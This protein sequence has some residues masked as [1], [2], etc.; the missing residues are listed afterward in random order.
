MIFPPD[1]GFDIGRRSGEPPRMSNLSSQARRLAAGGQTGTYALNDEAV[2]RVRA[3]EPVLMLT[4]GDPQTPPHPA[5]VAATTE[6]VT[7]GRTHYS[8]VLGEPELRAAVAVAEGAA[9]DNVVI[10]PGAQAAGFAAISAVAESGDE[11]ILSDPHYATYPGIVAAT[12]ASAR[13]VPVRDDLSFDVAAIAAA[14][15]P[16]TRAIFLTSPSNPTGAALRAEDHAVLADLCVRHNLWLVIDEVYRHFRYDGAHV[17]AWA[18]GPA[19]RTIVL[20]SLS[21]SHAMTGYRLGWLIVPEPLIP[22]LDG[23]SA[24]ALFGVSQFVQDA[25]VAALALPEAALAAYRQGFA[26]RAA[27]V[28]ERANAMA[29]V[30][31]RMPAGGM[32][33]MLDIRGLMADDQA[34]ATR[35]LREHQVAVNPGSLFG[36][37]G[38]GHLRLSLTPDA[39]VLEEAMAR[40]GRL[41]AAIRRG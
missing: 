21:K 16:R 28:V 6:A 3:G 29:G 15:T 34:F 14:V 8:P 4:L 39:P 19:G 11:V 41:A 9:F 18:H 32:F 7:R 20:G 38:A 35:L 36:R 23:W 10:V 26:R 25:A 13:L 12:G 27:L 22:A 24:A 31:A 1:A 30:R 2:R 33:V 5:I 37:G 40:I 17:G